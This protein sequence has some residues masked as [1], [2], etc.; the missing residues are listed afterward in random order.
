MTTFH[1][2]IGRLERCRGGGVNQHLILI[3][4]VLSRPSSE[5]VF[6]ILL[7]TLDY[8]RNTRNL[9]HFSEASS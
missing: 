2:V 3:V 9:F 5:I 6:E 8:F 1:S 7:D 4:L